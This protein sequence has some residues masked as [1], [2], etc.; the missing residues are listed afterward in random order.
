MLEKTAYQ[1]YV[2]I[3]CPYQAKVNIKRSL[4]IYYIKVTLLLRVKNFLANEFSYFMMKQSNKGVNR[5][6]YQ[7]I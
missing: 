7:K 4:L 1:G 6:L 2:L 5:P 3:I